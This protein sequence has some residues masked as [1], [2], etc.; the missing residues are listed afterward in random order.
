MA[1]KKT[2][3]KKGAAKSASK[4][5]LMAWEKQQKWLEENGLA[6]L[7]MYCEDYVDMNVELVSTGLPG[8]DRLLHS[9]KPVVDEHGDVVDLVYGMPR[10]RDVEFWSRNPEVCK[11]TTMLQCIAA[12]QHTIDPK[13][14]VGMQTAII[15]TEKTIDEPYLNLNGVIT[16]PDPS[17]PWLFPV[18][19]MRPTV[20]MDT[21]QNIDIA[22]EQIFNALTTL[23]RRMDIIGIDS[24][25]AIQLKADKEKTSDEN[26]QV[27]GIAQKMSQHLARN[28]NKRATCVWL[29][30]TRSKVGAYSPSGGEVLTTMGGRGL[31]FYCSIRVEFS[32]VKKLEISGSD[33]PPYGMLIQAYTNKNKMS[34]PFRKCLMTYLFGKTLSPVA[35]YVRL[36]LEN[37]VIVKKKGWFTFGPEDNPIAKINGERNVYDFFD[38]NPD[39]YTIL[40]HAVDNNGEIPS[41]SEDEIEEIIGM[42]S[43][44]EP[45]AETPDAEDEGEAEGASA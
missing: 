7:V 18:R 21:D 35:D 34:P 22:A 39:K 25:A 29:N 41:A 24:I 30:Q 6:G 1:E 31:P 28:T 13:T 19:I 4:T 17:R 3:G 36:A 12:F 38:A 2:K 33:Q 9:G 32:M 10:G 5:E 44:P 16:R 20:K 45:P 37:G 11:T 23:N 40:K 8:F 26:V 15:D 14:G 43:V 42:E 27:G